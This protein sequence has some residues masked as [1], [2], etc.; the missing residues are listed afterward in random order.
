VYSKI[1]IL[2]A[3][4]RTD[5]GLSQEE[6]AQGVM[7]RKSLNR[8]ENGKQEIPAYKLDALL[9]RLGH[10]MQSAKPHMLMMGGREYKIHT[11]R[12]KVENCL[13]HFDHDGA[14]LLIKK[15]EQMPAFREG[16][17]K[18]FLLNSRAALCKQ[19]GHYTEAMTLLDSAIRITIPKFREAR[20]RFCLLTGVDITIVNQMA[21]LHGLLGDA[22]QKTHLLLMLAENIRKNHMDERE[23]TRNLAFVLCTLSSAFCEQNNY[24]DALDACEEAIVESQRNRVYGLLP[25]LLYNKAYYLH[26]LDS[27]NKID[28]LVRQAYY[29]SMACGM[30]NL[31]TE[32]KADAVVDFDITLD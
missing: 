18:Q 32:I 30:D 13:A 4:L 27:R 24:T 12:D 3:T 8:F 15:M 31:T 10:T 7:S 6:L 20:V 1:G 25:L 14:E 2:I 29:M 28:A 22:E 11:M 16:L 17:H 23:K 21:I 26:K 19:Q 9:Q 5:R